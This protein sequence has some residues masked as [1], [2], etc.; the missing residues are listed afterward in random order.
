MPT[1]ERALQIQSGMY[2]KV[3]L[4]GDIYWDTQEHCYRVL[5]SCSMSRI[6]QPKRY[7]FINYAANSV[8]LAR[9]NNGN[10]MP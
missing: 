5:E 6:R 10:W 4:L 9:N 7:Q 3:G 8:E 1:Y 2:R